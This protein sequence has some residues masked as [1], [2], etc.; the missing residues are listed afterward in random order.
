MSRVYLFL[1]AVVLFASACAPKAAQD[2]TTTTTTT[3]TTEAAPADGYE[4]VVI[5]GDIPSPAKEMRATMGDTKITVGYG[6]PSVKGRT[7]WGDLVPF[8]KVWRT[9]AND[10]S[11]FETSTNIKIQGKELAAG[12]Y[13]FFTIP[14]EG[15]KWTII[16][17]SVAEQWGAYK[18]DASKD[19][20]RVSVKAEATQTMS[21]TMEFVMEGNNLVLKWDKLTVPVSIGM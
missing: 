19:V 3:T 10:A 21:E 1:F 8:D 2:T 14:T 17:N 16:F 20:L 6:S 15:N 12:K 11:T 18:Y 7:V 4:T 5:K 13:G 9:G